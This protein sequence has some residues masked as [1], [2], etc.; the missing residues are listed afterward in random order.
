[1][2]AHGHLPASAAPAL[3]IEPDPSAAATRYWHGRGIVAFTASVRD[4]LL[5][6]RDSE[7]IGLLVREQERVMLGLRLRCGVR[8]ATEASMHEARILADAGLLELEGEVTRTTRDGEA[9]LNAVTV[10]LTSGV[11]T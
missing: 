4:G 7:S 9:L 8:L 10:R 5:P 2:G 3:G 1:V 6:I 11:H